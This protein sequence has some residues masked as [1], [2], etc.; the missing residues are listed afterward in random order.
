VENN[1][2]FT[3]LRFHDGSSCDNG[4]INNLM[5]VNALYINLSSCA[6]DDL[7]IITCN[8]SICTTVN[9]SAGPYFTVT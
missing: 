4:N 3:T 2:N 1:D 9:E 7:D 5:V 8:S 6:V